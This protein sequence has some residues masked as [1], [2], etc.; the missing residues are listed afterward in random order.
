M[1]IKNSMNKLSKEARIILPPS[2]RSQITKSMAL[3]KVDHLEDFTK[4]SY[5]SGQ[6]KFHTLLSNSSLLNGLSN[7]FMITSLLLE[8]KT[9]PS[10][11]NCQLLLLQVILLVSS[12]QLFLILQILWLVNFTVKV[13]VKDQQVQKSQPFIKKSDSKDSGLVS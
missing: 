1:I 12:V 8:K 13:K 9:I 3:H 6:D 10:Q 11:L 5:H 4:V 7:Y 2:K